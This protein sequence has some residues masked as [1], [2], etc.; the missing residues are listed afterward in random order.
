M[1]GVV[2]TPIRFQTYTSQ[3]S[4][5]V[6][7]KRGDRLAELL[8]LSGELVDQVVAGLIGSS[9]RPITLMTRLGMDI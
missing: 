2:P 6:R 5:A 7:E 8:V 3:I 1:D 9:V 4:K